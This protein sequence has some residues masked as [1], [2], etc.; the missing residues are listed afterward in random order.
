MEQLSF[1][2]EHMVATNGAHVEVA[3]L[4]HNGHN[5]TN[6]GSIVDHS[7]GVVVGYVGKGNTLTTFDGKQL[8]TVREV[9]KWRTPNSF[10]SSH[11]H[12]YRA[13][14]DGKRYHGRGCGEG[15]ILRL[16]ADKVK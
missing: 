5:F 8:G 10:M 4:T 1:A 3:T 12:A 16:F 15:M 6:L 7:R 11:M 2:V 14:I 9:S 13:V